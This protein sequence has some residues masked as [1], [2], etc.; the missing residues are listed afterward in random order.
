[1]NQTGRNHIIDS[2]KSMWNIQIQNHVKIENKLE[3]NVKKVYVILFKEFCPSQM[4][5]RIK[6]HHEYDSVLKN[7]LKLIGTIAHSMHG[8]IQATYPYI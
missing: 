5:N 6:E 8:I 3:D 1:M 4:K 7:P 2:F